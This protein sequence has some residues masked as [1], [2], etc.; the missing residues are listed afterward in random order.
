MGVVA[1]L[2]H[3][4]GGWEG[5]E[6][7][8]ARMRDTRVAPPMLKHLDRGDVLLADKAF[9]NYEFLARLTGKG[10]HFIARLHQARHR[11]PDWRKGKKI[12]RN[13]RIII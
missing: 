3:S 2:N 9:C 7:N 11:K 13:E 8:N 6:T 10:S 12:R 5:F 4:H 1:L